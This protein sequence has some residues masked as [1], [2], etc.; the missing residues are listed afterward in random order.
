M[1]LPILTEHVRGST[2]MSSILRV[3]ATLQYSNEYHNSCFQHKKHTFQKITDAVSRSNEC[4][5]DT[6]QRREAHIPSSQLAPFTLKVNHF[7]LQ[8]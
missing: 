7:V 8:S 2:G 3:R 4:E 5:R 6:I 1:S